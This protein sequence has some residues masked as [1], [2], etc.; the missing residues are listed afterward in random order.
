MQLRTNSTFAY[1]SGK[2]AQQASCP[3]TTT[4]CADASQGTTL[5]ASTS[6]PTS[7]QT[8][9][10]KAFTQAILSDSTVKTALTNI[11]NATGMPASV[12]TR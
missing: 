8:F 1:F 6:C 5:T 10:S 7:I 3:A 9:T 2:A 4:Q 12:V 11:G